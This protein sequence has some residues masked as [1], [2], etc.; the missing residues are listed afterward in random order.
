MATKL[1][2]VR[3]EGEYSDYG[4]ELLAAGDEGSEEALKAFAAERTKVALIWKQWDRAHHSVDDPCPLSAW[5]GDV[6]YMIERVPSVTGPQGRLETLEAR[7][8]ALE[9][10]HATEDKEARYAA[11]S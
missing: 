6:M 3:H 7:I 11:W 5:H 8:E 9:E 2:L 4:V 10:R 1:V